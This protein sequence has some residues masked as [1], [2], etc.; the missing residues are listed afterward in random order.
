MSNTIKA[1][2]AMLI[3]TVAMVGLIN[4]IGF[5]KHHDN[6][7]WAI[8]GAIMLVITLVGN[9]WLFIGLAKEEPWAWTKDSAE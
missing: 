3:W 1:L 9:V 8:G 5:P 7:I 4:F 2:G 6:L